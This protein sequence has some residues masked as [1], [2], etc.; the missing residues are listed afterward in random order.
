MI[1]TFSVSNYRSIMDKQSIS[2]LSTKD[3]NYKH[4]DTQEVAK[5]VYINKL[6][7]FLGPNAS[8]KSN[9][10]YAL[11]AIVAMMSVPCNDKKNRI[12][13]Y[14]PFKMKGDSSCL[15]SLEFYIKGSKY[16]YDLEFNATEIVKET[17]YYVPSRSKALLY[18]RKYIGEDKQPSVTFGST[19]GLFASTKEELLKHTYNNST[20]LSTVAKLSLKEDAE[21]LTRIFKWAD[22]RVLS[23][24]N[25]NPVSKYYT[26]LQEIDRN[27]EKKIL[28]MDLMKKADFNIS[29]LKVVESP[30]VQNGKI[31]VYFTNHS[32][33][34]DFETPLELQSEG[35]LRFIDLVDLLY[36]VTNGNYVYLL[37]ELGN[38]L[39]YELIVYFLKMFL[40]NSES[41]QL[42]FTTQSLLL[43]NEDFI[44]N[45][46]IYLTEKEA[47]SAS[48][49]YERVSDIGLRRGTPLY[50]WYRIG[51]L[52][53]SPEVGSPYIAQ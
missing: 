40:Y 36:N 16:N 23:S 51:K 6:A 9:I 38:K 2:F 21:I 19:I 8:G 28:F 18:S 1:A 15:M 47:N 5:G 12:I 35:T 20:I 52:G 39:H 26:D 25:A 7:I 32:E 22:S 11:K 27:E 24:G 44:R 17:L 3:K 42:I 37:D 13:H 4:L 49:T 45:D 10:L 29:G 34:G 31:D 33:G 30:D 46:M 14:I 50:K 41:S 43:L 48:S 53:A